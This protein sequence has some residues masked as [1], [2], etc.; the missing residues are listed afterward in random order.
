MAQFGCTLE[1]LENISQTL[2]TVRKHSTGTYLPKT[3]EWL[4]CCIPETT[5]IYLPNR[6]EEWPVLVVYQKTLDYIFQ[7]KNRGVAYFGCMSENTRIYLPNKDRRMAYFGPMPGN[8]RIY[9]VLWL[10]LVVCPKHSHL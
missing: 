3:E 7:N 1:T 8:T 10:T 4:I 9:L 6:T 5:R 2:L